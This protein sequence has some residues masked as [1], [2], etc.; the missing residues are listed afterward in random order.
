MIPVWGFEHGNMRQVDKDHIFDVEQGDAVEHLV[1]AGI[2]EHKDGLCE[3]CLSRFPS[4]S[5]GAAQ[6]F[7]FQ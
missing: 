7:L 2:S 5:A 1:L 4:C 6:N 3:E